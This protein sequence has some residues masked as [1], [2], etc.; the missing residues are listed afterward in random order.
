MGRPDDR[1]DGGGSPSDYKSFA[2]PDVNVDITDLGSY[3]LEMLD[4]Q[5][6]ATGP[7]A[8]EVSAMTQLIQEGLARP[9]G[10]AGVFPEGAAAAR[11][12]SHR[13]SDF[14][15]FLRDV[16]DGIRNIGSAALV[17]AEM[18]EGTDRESA[19]GLDD[20]SFAFSDPGAKPPPG[21]R[22]VESWSEYETRMA[23]QSGQTAMALSG[24]DDLARVIY[25]ANGV[26]IYLYP[27]GS[28]KQVTTTQSSGSYEV[29]TTTTT[30]FYGPGSVVLQTTTEQDS[31]V[32]GGYQV[33]STTTT[34]GDGGSSRT[35]TVTDPDG[36]MTVTNETTVTTTGADGKPKEQTTTSDPVVI[37]PGQH[38][39]E[40]DMGPVQQAEQ[41]LDTAGEDWFV[42]EF[43]R[44]Y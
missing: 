21:F 18:Y 6:D 3:Y 31:R 41:Q 43:G 39:T 23:Q 5:A 33:Q 14:Q 16:L 36:T 20:V 4:V 12:L 29:G 42:K 1:G 34:R 7:A 38:R 15:Y 35:S 25:P 8:M 24:N 22:P 2:G 44:G 26:T 37:E 13:Q 27:D 30:T 19:A 17:V 40:P 32:Y 9:A 10:A 11:L 28:S